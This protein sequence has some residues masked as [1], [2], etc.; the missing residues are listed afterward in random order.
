MLSTIIK[1][2]SFYIFLRIVPDFYNFFISK[3][4][5]KVVWNKVKGKWIIITGATDGIGKELALN[6]AKRKYNI[7]IMGRSSSKLDEVYSLIIKENVKCKKIICDFS[8]E[9]ITSFIN[10]S[11]EIGMLINN[12]GCVGEHPKLF[13]EESSVSEMINVNIYNTFLLTQKVLISMMNRKNGVILNIG[14]FTG[15]MP[16][17]V[18][19]VYSSTKAMIRSWSESLHYEMRPYN[20]HVECINTG[21]VATKMSKIK[22]PSF[23]VPSA[24]TY[25]DSVLNSFGNSSVSITYFPHL[26][27]YSVIKIL[28][29]TFLGIITFFS[30][31][32]TRNMAIEKKKIE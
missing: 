9:C 13:G 27:M 25:A 30:L 26:L 16:C 22:K 8:K 23:F 15:D 7:I 19:S 29:R 32:R 31:S 21:Y 3:L 14:S 17:P 4:K 24:K 12:V 2:V 6:A 18:L 11:I 20:V 10:D 5:N 28:P 1:Y